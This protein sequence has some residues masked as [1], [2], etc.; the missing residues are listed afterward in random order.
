M[1]MRDVQFPHEL[2]TGITCVVRAIGSEKMETHIV[3]RVDGDDND[4][5]GK[6]FLP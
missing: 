6:D 5:Q 1:N 3:F 2:P 4:A